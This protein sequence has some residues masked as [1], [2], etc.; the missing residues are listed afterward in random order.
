MAQHHVSVGPGH[1]ARQDERARTVV[2]R[3]G[4]GPDRERAPAT[5]LGQEG[6]LGLDHP[7]HRGVVD[8]AQ[9]RPGGRVVGPAL[10]GQGPLGHLGDHGLRIEGLDL[11]PLG[12]RPGESVEGGP[13]GHHR[14]DPVRPDAGQAGGQVPP[15]VGE[16]QVGPEVGELDAPAGRARRHRRPG[17]EP[18]EARPDQH[19]AGIAPLGKGGQDEPGGGQLR[20]GGQVLGRVHGGV[21]VAPGHGGLDLLDEHALTAQPGERHV[22]APVTLGVDHHQLGHPAGGGQQTG[23]ALG[24]PHGQ[25]RAPGGQPEP[26]GGV[27]HAEGP[28]TGQRSNRARRDSTRRSPRG[29]PAASF[30]TTVG[31]W[32]SLATMARVTASTCSHW[33]SSR[34]DRLDR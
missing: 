34:S 14:R 8:G 13:G 31:W 23:D 26:A 25:R 10:D 24:L 6:A 20:R 7:A 16:G 3:H 12:R 29:V 33:A 11:H 28:V 32:S 18:V 30:R 2:G 17:G 5:Q 27:G 4:M 15:E 1:H 22:G 19:V 9:G 21:G